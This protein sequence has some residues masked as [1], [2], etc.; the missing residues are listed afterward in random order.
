M[1]G[2]EAHLYLFDQLLTHFEQEENLTN[3][4][5]KLED[6]LVRI[7]EILDAATPRSIVIMNEIFTSTTLQDAVFLG[8]RVMQRIVDLDLL[9]VCVT[10]IDELAALSDKIVSMVSTVTPED[11]SK[12]R[13]RSCGGGPTGSRMRSRSPK[14]IA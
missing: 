1:P 7:H 4:R 6:E 13:T 14:S 2:R 8:E 5:G 3:L 11:L 9:C 10:F 12:R